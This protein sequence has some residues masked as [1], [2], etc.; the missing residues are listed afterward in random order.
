MVRSGQPTTIRLHSFA[1]WAL[2]VKLYY[3]LAQCLAIGSLLLDLASFQ[4]RRKELVLAVLSAST[5]L[6]AAQYAMLDAWTSSAMMLLAS[7]RFLTSSQTS[8]PRVEPIFLIAASVVFAALP[9]TPASFLAWLGNCVQTHA[10]FNS[11]DKRMRLQMMLGS[12]LWITH[13]VYISAWVS[14]LA[15][16]GFLL[17]NCVGYY[18]F[19]VASRE[20]EA[21]TG[22]PAS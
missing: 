1:P 18:R 12:G 4:L 17:S 9:L 20:P 5:C 16:T 14:V 2:F 22:A 8:S 19:H 13:N 6:L 7:I 3:V 21:T 15:E 11:S 10:A